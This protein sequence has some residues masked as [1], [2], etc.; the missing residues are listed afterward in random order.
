MTLSYRYTPIR[1]SESATFGATDNVDVKTAGLV[2]VSGDGCA[3]N[4]ITETLTGKIAVIKRGACSFT[5]KVKAAQVKGAVAVVVDNNVPGDLFP[6][7]GTDATVTIPARFVTDTDGATLRGLNAAT[8]SIGP[9]G[10]VSACTT[11]V[12]NIL[13]YTINSQC[14]QW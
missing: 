9:V 12:Y 14:V 1:T 2:P 13:V 10:Q 5:E 4:P 3:A 6:L 8:A 7:G 11:I